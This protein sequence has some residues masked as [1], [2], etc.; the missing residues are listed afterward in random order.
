MYFI[1]SKKIFQYLYLNQV[2]VITG[3]CCLCISYIILGY[4]V[5]IYVLNKITI[6]WK[7]LSITFYFQLIKNCVLYIFYQIILFN[8]P[9]LV[10]TNFSSETILSHLFPKLTQEPITILVYRQN[11]KVEY[12]Q[13]SISQSSLFL[14]NMLKFKIAPHASYVACLT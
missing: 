10:V 5:L 4:I 2:F 11:M 6:M 8:T 13:T 12:M 14:Q 1:S 9:F 7:K 3:I